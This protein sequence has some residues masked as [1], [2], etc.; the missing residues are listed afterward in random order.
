MGSGELPDP[1]FCSFVHGLWTS[2]SSDGDHQDPH[3]ETKQDARCNFKQ[4]GKLAVEPGQVVSHYEGSTPHRAPARQRLPS[5]DRD[6]QIG[7]DEA[8]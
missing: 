3:S 1:P 6:G 5:R 2:T 8:D 4:A 7:I